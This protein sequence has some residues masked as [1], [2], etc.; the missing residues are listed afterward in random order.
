MLYA[1]LID[2]NER[3]Q[4]KVKDDNG[5]ALKKDEYIITRA[6]GEKIIMRPAKDDKRW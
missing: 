6:N 1:R 2:H 4:S 3:E 5:N